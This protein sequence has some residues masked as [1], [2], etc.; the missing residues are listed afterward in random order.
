MGRSSKKKSVN[1]VRNSEALVIKAID[2]YFQ[3]IYY[4]SEMG[5]Q[6]GSEMGDQWGNYNYPSEV[7]VGTP[8]APPKTDTP[9]S[10]ST[11]K[12]DIGPVA[13][14]VPEV[15]DMHSM[16]LEDRFDPTTGSYTSES[17]L[18]EGDST[19]NAYTSQTPKNYTP[20]ETY[21][22]TSVPPTYSMG[23]Q[24]DPVTGDYMDEHTL[25]DLA[26]GSNVAPSSPVT[27]EPEPEPEPTVS[28]V[29]QPPTD[30]GWY[31]PT[32]P[33]YADPMYDNAMYAGGSYDGPMAMD[34]GSGD[35]TQYGVTQ[36]G[37][38]QY[39][40][41]QEAAGTAIIFPGDTVGS[42]FNDV[43][44]TGSPAERDTGAPPTSSSGT[45]GLNEMGMLTGGTPAPGVDEVDTNEND[46][47]F[48]G[49]AAYSGPVT[50]QD[51]SN[52]IDTQN[53]IVF[54]GAG[55]DTHEVNSTTSNLQ[56]GEP[57]HPADA[58]LAAAAPADIETQ[59]NAATPAP[60]TA[61]ASQAIGTQT[62][63]TDTPTQT[64]T[65]DT[66]S[67][68][69]PSAAAP[70]PGDSDLQI[71]FHRVSTDVCKLCPTSARCNG[72]HESDSIKELTGYLARYE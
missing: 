20:T 40:A 70:T 50:Q 9:K 71:G 28:Q 68:A 29:S 35:A 31:D 44:T 67:A 42:D 15:H 41:D 49:D 21:T 55:G 58:A 57:Y 25:A 32:D 12:T 5:D 39:I 8:V 46:S 26:P 3:K 38:D 63:T 56:T 54:P 59:A 18:M 14:S 11:E 37:Y 36:S 53:D 19:L 13:T 47:E 10:V 64:Q 66:P 22:P 23:E 6:Y 33:M 30:S 43:T 7:P 45:A 24:F 65:T 52:Y 34:P 60:V 27:P 61:D 4:G 48:L 1:A 72:N 2:S 62:Q 51:Y 69:A 17:E 16:N